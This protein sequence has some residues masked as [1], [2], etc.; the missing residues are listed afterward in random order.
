MKTR[1][2]YNT[3]L[4]FLAATVLLS[5]SAYLASH[6]SLSELEASIFTA[7]YDTPSFL[8]PVFTVTTQAGSIYVLMALAIIYL[9]IRHYHIVIRLLMSGLLSYVLAGVAKD[10]FGRPRPAELLSNLDIVVRDFYVHGPGYPSGHTALATAIGL[11]LA[12]HLP[13]PWKWLPITGIILVGWSRVYLGAHAPLDIV[14]GFAIGWLSVLLFQ[15]VKLADI[16]TRV[17][18]KPS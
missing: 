13:R 16:R 4:Q 10:V 8:R 9:F 12:S 11:I 5:A 7:L 18:K 3:Q 1:P 17:L 2:S 15:H 14:G 6:H